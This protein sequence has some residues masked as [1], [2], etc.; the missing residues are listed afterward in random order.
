MKTISLTRTQF[1]K[2][3][4]FNPGKD[5]INTEAEL[6]IIGSLRNKNNS[7]KLLKK[8]F[9]DEGEYFGRKLLNLN[10][11][12]NYREELSYVDELVLPESLA[13]IA[14]QIIG[15][16][17]PLVEKSVNLQTVLFD[18]KIRLKTKLEYLKQIGS[19]LQKVD[20]LKGIP[21]DF[22]IGDL[23]EANFVIDENNNIRIV[24]VDSCYFSNN[25]P[26]GARYLTSSLSTKLLDFP[27]KYKK[28]NEDLF[29]PTRD[30]DLYCFNM[31]L[32]NTL[33]GVNMSAI[34]TTSFYLYMNYLESIGINKNLLEAIE[35]VYHNGNNQST[36][37][38]L[39]ELIDIEP[40]QANSK[41]YKLKTGLDLK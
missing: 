13:I 10:T 34:S 33:S 30:T 25:I 11:L 7:R 38:Y 37:P 24:Y 32:L 4:R 27:Y 20:D 40:Y 5:I 9:V 6:F 39:D 15:Y 12:M 8:F 28:F 26:F 18:D 35:S 16:T 41:V 23:R 3:K 22:R 36:L 1:E 17:M 29:I 19:A 2:L 21:Y 31:I 14:G